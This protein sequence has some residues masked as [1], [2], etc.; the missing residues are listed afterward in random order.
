M[1]NLTP[2]DLYA[3]TGVVSDFCRGAAMK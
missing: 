1:P 3:E 2:I